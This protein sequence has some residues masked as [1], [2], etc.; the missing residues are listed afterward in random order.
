MF[1]VVLYTVEFQKKGNTTCAYP[2]LFAQGIEIVI[3][4][5]HR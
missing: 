5:C 4:N 1:Y 2:T 3:N